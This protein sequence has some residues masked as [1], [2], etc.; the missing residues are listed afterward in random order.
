MTLKNPRRLTTAQV[1]RFRL[2]GCLSV[3]DVLTADEVAA[4]GQHTDRIAAGELDHIPGDSI[5]LE[6]VFRRGEKAVADKVLAVR[7]LFKL[8]AYDEVMWAHVT[9]PKIADMAADLLGTDDIKLYSDQLFMKGPRTGSAQVWHQDSASWRDILPMDLVTAWTAIDAATVDNG[10]LNFAIG[11]HRCGLLRGERLH[12]FVADLE[13]G[14]WPVRSAPLRPGGVSFH[15]SLTLHQSNANRSGRRRRGYAV[16]YMRASSWRDHSAT[17]VPKVP[18]FR[19]V[20][21]RS[22]PGRV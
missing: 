16:H 11:T 22:F 4:L 8:A 9:H 7:K 1:E 17:G 12:P 3:E 13:G 6:P 19:Q 20:R 15:H 14:L 21:G 5:Q 10:C 18:P 2:D